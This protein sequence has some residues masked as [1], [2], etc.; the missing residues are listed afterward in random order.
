MY[1]GGSQKL[2]DD[3]ACV[4]FR[5]PLI[6]EVENYDAVDRGVLATGPALACVVG[7]I[8]QLNLLSYPP[9]PIP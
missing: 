3:L 5:N 7:N 2:D 8:I 1:W 4:N 9:S 6:T